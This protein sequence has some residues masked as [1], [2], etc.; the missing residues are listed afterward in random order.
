MA[1]VGTEVAV[2]RG[3]VSFANRGIVEEA[4]SG[5]V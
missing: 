4:K 2:R 3:G 5:L 1:K